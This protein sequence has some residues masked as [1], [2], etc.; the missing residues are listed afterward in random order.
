MIIEFII[1]I[2]LKFVENL[3]ILVIT[4]TGAVCS[5]VY[6]CTVFIHSWFMAVIVKSA[7]YFRE[8]KE[9]AVSVPAFIV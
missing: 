5:F 4:I 2:V 7:I 6:G 9:R 3:L 1:M 8:L